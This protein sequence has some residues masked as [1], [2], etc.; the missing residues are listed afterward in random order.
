VERLAEF[1]AG[2][3]PDDLPRQVVESA[4]RAILD[5]LG[6]AVRG[7]LEP[8]ADVIRGVA[9]T[10]GG[11]PQAS[12]LGRGY[13]TGVAYAA[14][15]NGA[16]GHA[17]DYDDTH[18]G[19]LVHGSAAVLPAV[20]A[21]AEWLKCG[22]L[23]A[24]TAF[25]AGFEVESHVGSSLGKPLT[26]RGWH[27]TGI[28]GH[29][30]AAAAVAKLLGLPPKETANA[31]SIAGVQCAGVTRSFGT[32]SKPLQ[33]GKAAMDGVLSAFLAQRGFTGPWDILEAR[34]G[35]PEVLLGVESEMKLEGLGYDFEILR[36]SFKP[37]AACRL[38]HPVIDAGRLIRSRLGTSVE[39]VESV[40]CRISPLAFR[41]ANNPEPH[42]GLQAKFSVQFCAAL[43]LLRGAADETC[44]SET[45]VREPGVRRLMTKV[46]LEPDA[47]VG[48]TQ[49]GMAVT[50]PDGRREEIFVAAC[51]GDP[52]NPM[53]D[54]Q[55]EAKFKLLAGKVLPADRVS[56]ILSMVR[57]V[58]S[59][60]DVGDLVRSACLLGN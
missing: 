59:L 32:M 5:W 38:T 14:F 7:S 31:L 1:V 49:A 19:S 4:K 50:L 13:R 37:Y 30:G 39:D 11:I 58:E 51:L 9:E 29:F 8:L 27:A 21:V 33:A 26:H 15:G 23:D 17:L 2:L 47:T 53:T 22:G 36:N 12:V 25:V 46:R 20:L 55:L 41:V 57:H 3:R 10:L 44:F 16:Q 54:E 43:S 24:L 28:L 34:G 52:E 56:R 40:E 6:V 35:L 18:M 48:E 60:S 42:D 45:A